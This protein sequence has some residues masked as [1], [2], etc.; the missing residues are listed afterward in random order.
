[1]AAEPMTPLRMQLAAIDTALSNAP[2]TR[3]LSTAI[4]A[5]LKLL[6][7]MELSRIKNFRDSIAGVQDA[8][9]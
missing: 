7:N 5:I 4:H 8:P 3:Q 2:T 6:D 9:E 1:M